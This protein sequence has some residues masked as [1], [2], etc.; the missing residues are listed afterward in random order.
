MRKYAAE[1]LGTYILVFCGTG[2]ILIDALTGGSI[3]HTGISIT[4]GLVVM[5]MIYT[6]GD[7]SG[8]HINPAVSLAF[9]MDKKLGMRDL[10]IYITAQIT[11]AILASATLR[12]L[13]AKA[14]NFGNTLP[15]GSEVQAFGMET[16][17]S[18]ILMLVI[19]SVSTKGREQGIMAGLAIG[20]VVLFEAMFAGPVTGASMNPARSIGPAV[21]SGQFTSLWIYLLAP[22]CGMFLAVLV[23]KF[24]AKTSK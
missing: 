20:A 18:F 10:L 11:G 6:F 1:F 17:L 21:V 4:F 9:F 8:A 16:I 19:L 13:F 12:L 5:V 7:L 15:S 2:A 14:T 3:G 23:W 22:V 24:L